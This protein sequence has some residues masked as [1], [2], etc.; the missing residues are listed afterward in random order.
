[1]VSDVWAKGGQGGLELAEEVV[2][3]CETPE[4][5]FRF[6]YELD[7]PIARKAGG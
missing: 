2:R 1:M 5:D 4:H 3:L 6:T 7:Q